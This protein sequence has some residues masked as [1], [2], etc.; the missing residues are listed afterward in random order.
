M[1]TETFPKGDMLRKRLFH[2]DGV[3]LVGYGQSSVV[4]YRNKNKE[5]L[6]I[7][8]YLTPLPGNVSPL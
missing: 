8:K 2:F 3:F 4:V 1:V 5:N 6:S 7:S